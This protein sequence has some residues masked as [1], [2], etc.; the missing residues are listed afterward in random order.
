MKGVWGKQK[1]PV[2]VPGRKNSDFESCAK[3]EIRG[4]YGGGAKKSLCTRGTEATI[5]YE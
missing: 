4:N 3:K 5:I 2:V 1:C